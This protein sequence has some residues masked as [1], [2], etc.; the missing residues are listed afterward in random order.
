VLWLPV[1]P[2][3]FGHVRWWSVFQ[4]KLERRR[5]G[6]EKKRREP[7][8]LGVQLQAVRRERRPNPA[9]RG[10]AGGP[11]AP[12]VRYVPVP[13]SPYPSSALDPPPPLLA[14][15][16]GVPLFLAARWIGGR[17]RR[18]VGF[19]C[20]GPVSAQAGW[21]R[22]GPGAGAGGLLLGFRS[23]GFPSSALV[24]SPLNFIMA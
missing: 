9:G 13:L 23:V 21:G 12:S 20:R 3:P 1:R 24:Q 10:G 14:R 17:A 8:S 19:A 7:K 18:L 15:G 5:K 16:T 6:R 11:P 22:Y 2:D 4:P